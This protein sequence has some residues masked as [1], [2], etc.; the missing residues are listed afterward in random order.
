[1]GASV[2]FSASVS[3]CVAIPH[4][5]LATTYMASARQRPR[6]LASLTTVLFTAEGVSILNLLGS[7]IY[8][9]YINKLQTLVV[10]YSNGGIF[11]LLYLFMIVSLI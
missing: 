4:S 3:L 5:L 9:T 11:V 1:M 2:P 10:I 8:S 6:V 7:G